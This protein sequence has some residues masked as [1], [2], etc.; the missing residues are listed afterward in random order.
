MSDQYDPQQCMPIEGF[1]GQYAVC[2]DGTVWSLHDDEPTKKQ[3]FAGEHGPRVALYR[4]G[5]RVYQPY[6]HVLVRRAF[7]D[8]RPEPR[9]LGWYIREHYGDADEVEEWIQD[10]FSQESTDAD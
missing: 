4:F 2:P 6:V 8:E 3:T 5:R 9:D 1:D 10:T 7:G